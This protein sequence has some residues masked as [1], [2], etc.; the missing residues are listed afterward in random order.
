MMNWTVLADNRTLDP[1]LETEHGLAILLQTGAYRILLDTGASNLL[2]RNA[3]K[4][5]ISLR[6]LDYV[7]VSHGH[8]DHAGGLRHVLDINPGTR[9]IVSPQAFGRRFFSKR[10][11]LH[12]ITPPWPADLSSRLMSADTFDELPDGLHVIRQ[13]PRLNPTP[14]AN[15]LLFVQNENEN[16]IADDFGH[17]MAFYANGLLFTGCAHNGLEN[18][19]AAC[20][21]PIHI[22]VGGFHLP[23][24]TEEESAITALAQRLQAAYP[25]VRFFTSHC[26]GDHTFSLMKRVM[27]DQL[28][29][30]SCGTHFEE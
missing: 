18:I 2:L 1:R 15:R 19:L 12:E 4:L 26:T 23:D 3:E 11:H 7:F 14:R 16:L 22:V 27:G 10:N 24:G 29:A 13:I 21:W 28:Q 8:A 20:S 30:F 9:V 25:T 5:G 17:E 6:N